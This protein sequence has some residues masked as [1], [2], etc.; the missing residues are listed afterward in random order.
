MIGLSFVLVAVIASGV[1]RHMGMPKVNGISVFSSVWAI[2]ALVADAG[3]LQPTMVPQT[4]AMLWIALVATVVGTICGWFSAGTPEVDARA[5]DSIERSTLL[6]VHGVCLTVFAAYWA[7]Q[8]AALLPL[9]LAL[10]G[11]EAVFSTSGNGFRS[12]GIEASVAHAQEGFGSGSGSLPAALLGYLLYLVGGASIFTGSLLWQ[13]GNR[14]L[15]VAPLVLAA[16][17]SLLTL[18]RTTVVI[19]TF[20][21]VVSVLA[22]RWSGVT[23]RTSQATASPPHA[24]RTS[25]RT[26]F[27]WTAVGAV[28]LLLALLIPIQARNQGTTKAVGL[29]SLMQYVFAG[30][31][32]LNSRNV[33][34][35]DWHP[36]AGTIPG[37]LDASYGWGA[38]TFTAIFSILHRLGIP[39]PV[40]PPN[41]DYYPVAIGG[42]ESISNVG[43]LLTDAFLDAG[44]WGV[45]LIPLVLGIIAGASQRRIIGHQGVAFI[46]LTAYVLTMILWSF[47]VAGLGDLRLMLLCLVAGPALQRMLKPR[48]P[49]DKAGKSRATNSEEGAA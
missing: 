28:V 18:Q 27:I 21:F 25:K 34:N 24:S 11:W 22:Q 6:T 30:I 26:G 29:E 20:V 43:T 33:Y 23:V 45:A 5:G 40:T 46:P 4:W 41:L 38:Y 37:S 16:A 3:Y 35:P 44:W 2:L 9:V 10:G 7:I 48:T 47:F 1:A 17:Y 12:A 8:I 31:S 39:V 14:V 42:S 36:P 13:A 32:G 19:L 49:P 15:A